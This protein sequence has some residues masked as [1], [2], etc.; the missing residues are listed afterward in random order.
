MSM[1]KMYTFLVPTNMPRKPDAYEVSSPSEVARVARSIGMTPSGPMNTAAGEIYNPS[2]TLM[3]LVTVGKS[4][5]EPVDI[6]PVL[7]DPIH[8]RREICPKI[9]PVGDRFVDWN[10]DSHDYPIVCLAEEVTGHLT[11]DARKKAGRCF[12]TYWYD[13]SERTFLCE[14]T[15]SFSLAPIGY[16]SEHQ[17]DD[18]LDAELSAVDQQYMHCRTVDGMPATQKTVS[19]FARVECDSDEEFFEEV[20]EHFQG[21]PPG[22]PEIWEEREQK[23]E[24]GLS[25]EPAF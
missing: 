6:Q 3:A 7:M 25:Q 14:S 19:F 4:D 1:K 18:E 15:P 10:A 12:S 13:A 2:G 22:F 16:E 17:V 5:E 9:P 21:N 20:A 11:E 24:A 23:P 8:G